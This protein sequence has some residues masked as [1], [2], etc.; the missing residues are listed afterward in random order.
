MRTIVLSSVAL[1]VMLVAGTA[2]AQVPPPMQWWPAGA[3]TSLVSGLSSTAPVRVPITSTGPDDSVRKFALAGIRIWEKSD[4]PCGLEF[5]AHKLDPASLEVGGAAFTRDAACK[6]SGPILPKKAVLPVGEFVNAIQVCMNGRTGDNA[7]VKGIQ[8]IG[9]RFDENGRSQLG[10]T[11]IFSRPNCKTWD[12]Q[13]ASCG[14]DRVATAVFVHTGP[15][16]LRGLSLECHAA[17][18]LDAE[19]P[20]VGARIGGYGFDE[21]NGGKISVIVAMWNTFGESLTTPPIRVDMRGD[22]APGVGRCSGSPA[23]IPRGMVLGPESDILNAKYV[24]I[25]FACSWADIAT[26]PGCE[27]VATPH[28]VANQQCHVKLD[29]S[30]DGRVSSSVT[31]QLWRGG[32]PLP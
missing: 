6:S 11:V 8:L 30:V 31:G 7:V 12:R 5:Y 15:R 20:K 9:V 23:D 13:Y 32:N 24:R 16:G 1:G 29:L 17:Y 22:G 21:A 14:A 19:P 25:D 3:S 18:P 4:D 26:S 27:S 2:A 10:S 28:E